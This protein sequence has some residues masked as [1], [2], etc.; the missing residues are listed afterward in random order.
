VYGGGKR[1]AA[2]AVVFTQIP[3]ASALTQL[4]VLIVIVIPCVASLTVCKR[5]NL[6]VVYTCGNV[7]MV[8][9]VEVICVVGI[10]CEIGV[11]LLVVEEPPAD[12]AFEKLIHT[13]HAA[14]PFSARDVEVSVVL[15]GK[16]KAFLTERRIVEESLEHDH[17]TALFIYDVRVVPARKSDVLA[18]L[19]RREGVAF[20]RI[21]EKIDRVFGDVASGDREFFHPEAFAVGHVDLVLLRAVIRKI[22]RAAIKPVLGTAEDHGVP[23]V[24]A[25]DV[26]LVAQRRYVDPEAVGIVRGRKEDVPVHAVAEAVAQPLRRG[27]GGGGYRVDRACVLGRNLRASREYRGG[28]DRRE[29][30]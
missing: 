11:G 26:S 18:Q 6:R 20:V 2:V 9:V 10:L 4:G 23:A 7:N 19:L 3:E 16:R 15:H 24:S 29:R 22:A 17:V 27:L 25:D 28:G 5:R 13:V 12:I 14:A 1:C 8:G 21:G 30:K